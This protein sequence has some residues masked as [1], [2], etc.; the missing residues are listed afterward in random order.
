M[1]TGS[2]GAFWT[3][4]ADAPRK[5][6]VS[7]PGKV[8]SSSHGVRPVH[9]IITMVKWIRISRL[10]IKKSPSLWGGGAG[11]TQTGDLRPI[12]GNTVG[13]TVGII[14]LFSVRS[15]V[16][17]Y[18]DGGAVLDVFGLL[19]EHDVRRKQ[20]PCTVSGTLKCEP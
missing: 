12:V 5:V 10:S 18:A 3:R 7:L 6:D 15:P 11:D 2:E 9:L 19:L 4:G 20:P 1:Y 14:T 8:D 13:N 17:L 16:D